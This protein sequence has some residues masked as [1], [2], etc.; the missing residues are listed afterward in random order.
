MELFSW[1]LSQF[2][3]CWYIEKKLSFV[4]LYLLLVSALSVYEILEYCSLVFKIF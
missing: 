3:H 4:Y 2:V 1:F